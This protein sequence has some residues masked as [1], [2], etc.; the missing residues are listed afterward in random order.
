MQKSFWWWQCSRNLSSSIQILAIVKEKPEQCKGEKR[1]KTFAFC[2]RQ[3]S[4][5]YVFFL[6]FSFFPPHWVFRS[7]FKFVGYN[8]LR[9]RS[10]TPRDTCI[11][12]FHLF[13]VTLMLLSCILPYRR[14]YSH[15]HQG[16]RTGECAGK[17]STF[18]LSSFYSSCLNNFSIICKGDP[19]KETLWVLLIG[20]VLWS[21][22]WQTA[23]EKQA[24]KEW[25]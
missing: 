25:P 18:F 11:H 4:F 21:V 17:L 6:F 24:P 16:R 19:S 20:S 22:L 14:V 23:G 1:G 5:P 12:P 15:I 13:F 9:H 3:S 7:P 2:A 8:I 10:C